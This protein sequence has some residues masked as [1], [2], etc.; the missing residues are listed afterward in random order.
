VHVNERDEVSR[1]V[2]VNERD[3]VAARRHLACLCPVSRR[4]G[5]EGFV[6]R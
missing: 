1:H 3:E 5:T 4:L 2:H 6:T